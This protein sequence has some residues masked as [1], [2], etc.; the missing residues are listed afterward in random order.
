MKVCNHVVSN[1]RVS[2]QGVLAGCVPVQRTLLQLEVVR[3]LGQ[4]CSRSSSNGGGGG[5]GGGS[6]SS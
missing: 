6:S 1:V 4:S 2:R 5:G 3:I